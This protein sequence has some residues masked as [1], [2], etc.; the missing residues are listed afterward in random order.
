[1]PRPTKRR[2]YKERSDRAP[3]KTK[4]A[5][6][7]KGRMSA[8]L[9]TVI[10]FF[11]ALL[12]AIA[13]VYWD[14]GGYAN[15]LKALWWGIASLVVVTCGVAFT[16]YHNVVLP[17]KDNARNQTNATEQQSPNRP[18]LNVEIV[19]IGP[20]TFDGA[21]ANLSIEFRITNGG[22]MPAND[23][24]IKSDV[25]FPPFIG[26]DMIKVRLERQQTVCNRQ[27]KVILGP[28]V[29]FTGRTETFAVTHILQM[30]EIENQFP[31][32][33]SPGDGGKFMEPV[34]VGCVRYSFG[35]QHSLGKGETGFIHNV[36]AKTTS[37]YPNLFLKIGKDVP[38]SEIKLERFLLGGN[39]AK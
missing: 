21:N 19:P 25:F 39:Y 6:K 26:S 33:S 14:R 23:S 11:G 27:Q 22:H 36:R 37:T 34:I 31:P 17:S 18:W 9:S 20:L 16:F 30:S 1:M 7:Q 35:E 8:F 32:D 15:N 29:V 5:K 38:I 2:N 13:I 24:E 4:P 28:G 12:F 10:L 3:Q